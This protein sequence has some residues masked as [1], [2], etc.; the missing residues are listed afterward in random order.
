[1]YHCNPFVVGLF[2]NLALRGYSAF[3]LNSTPSSSSL[4]SL[5]LALPNGP[6]LQNDR[7]CPVVLRTFLVSIYNCGCTSAAGASLQLPSNK[8]LRQGFNVISE[9]KQTPYIPIY[10]VRL[11]PNYHRK[12]FSQHV[13]TVEDIHPASQLSLPLGGLVDPQNEGWVL[14]DRTSLAATACRLST[15]P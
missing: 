12:S 5:C 15:T 6:F 11:P 14:S 2:E 4:C 7:T 8:P 9:H 1:M 10:T 13:S 3:S